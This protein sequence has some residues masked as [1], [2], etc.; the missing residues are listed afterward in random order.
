VQAAVAVQAVEAVMEA[1][2][3]VVPAVQVQLHHTQEHQ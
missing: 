2:L 1:H 3:L